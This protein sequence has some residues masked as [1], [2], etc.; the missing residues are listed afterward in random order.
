[1]DP[2]VRHIVEGFCR[3]LY[4]VRPGLVETVYVTGS[5]LTEDWQPLHSDIDVVLI[6]SR[7]VS[8]DDERV[9]SELHSATARDDAHHGNPIDG[10]YL[11]A[12]QLAAGPDKI[13]TAPQVVDG[14]F[15]LDKPK[16][17][18]NWVTWLEL[19]ASP[20]G[21]IDPESGEM[22]WS[23]PVGTTPDVV[24]KAA[25][26]SFDNLATYWAGVAE[27]IETWLAG[28]EA[29]EDEAAPV[30]DEAVVWG[31]LG[32]PRLLATI[33]QGRVLSK[34]ESGEF[35][36]TRWPSYTNLIRRCQRSRAGQPVVFT[37]ADVR[38]CLG[39]LREVIGTGN[40]DSRHGV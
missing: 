29:P 27:Q 19:A 28:P 35:A 38:G 1:M 36:V 11:T 15:V 7:P 10:V 24:E 12:A 37:V 22:T 17:Q 18:L 21:R 26:H 20:V 40:S 34:S 33:E 3:H 23:A 14:L 9:L 16:G 4:G 13:E 32:A 5:A 31:V 30:P 25:H 8:V 2:R 6:V 39:L